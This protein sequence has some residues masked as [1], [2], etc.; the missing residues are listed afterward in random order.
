M[1]GLGIST[2]NRANTVLKLF[3]DSI[4][5]HGLSSQ[6]YGDHGTE[7]VL[8]AVYQLYAWGLNCGSY[9]FGKSV[10]NVRFERLW[11]DYF[12]GFIEAGYNLF[13]DL[14]LYHGLD[15]NNFRH[16]WLLHHL[17]LGSMRLAAQ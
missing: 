15:H 1:T 11:R 14:E 6:A 3:T 7:N 13:H 10:H 16:V 2:Y 5:K 9:F 12:V 4:Q 17:F 8:V